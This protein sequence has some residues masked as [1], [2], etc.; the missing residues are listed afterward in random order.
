MTS[1]QLGRTPAGGYC[2]TT[3][4][5]VFHFGMSAGADAFDAA[6]YESQAA[7]LNRVRILPRK[8]GIDPA[9][10]DH[11]HDREPLPIDGPVVIE[12]N[13]YADTAIVAN[14]DG[15]ALNFRADL[16]GGVTGLS[17]LKNQ[18]SGGAGVLVQ[19]ATGGPCGLLELD[20]V[21]VSV[22]RDLPELGWVHAVSING[23]PARSDP[24]GAR[25]ITLT[26]CQLF[27]GS[28]NVLQI[29][30]GKGVYCVGGQLFGDVLVGGTGTVPS[31][32]VRFIGTDIQGVYTVTPFT[33][34]IKR[35]V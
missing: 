16:G 17:I 10:C 33:N 2:V 28:A 26:N 35:I 32:N 5:A 6:V 1:I 8:R 11:F 9:L 30:G 22:Y 29:W 31:D 7:G 24:P 34:N 21:K 3:P 18:G 12:G 4:A 27:R 14:H 23:D 25:G 20:R 13:Q 15:V 19:T